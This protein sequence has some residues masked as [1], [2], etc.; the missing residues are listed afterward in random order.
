MLNVYREI[1]FS[2]KMFTNGLKLDLSRWAWVEKI[3]HGNGNTDI[4]IKKEFRAQ[5]SVKKVMQTVF[6]DMKES[7]T[8]DFPINS[9]L[10]ADSWGKI[11]LIY[12]INLVYICV[13]TCVFVYVCECIYISPKS[14]YDWIHIC[15]HD[16]T[17]ST[18]LQYSFLDKCTYNVLT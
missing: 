14:Y 4:P 12:V 17:N 16:P 1:S 11:H 13:R 5:Q 6:C 3:V 15:C 8:I 7:I 10:I 2:S 9:A 18:L